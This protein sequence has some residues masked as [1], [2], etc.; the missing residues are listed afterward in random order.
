MHGIHIVWRNVLFIA[1]Y[2]RS[3]ICMFVWLAILYPRS[4]TRDL[5]VT[6]NY[7]EIET[8]YICLLVIHRD[9][10]R[11]GGGQHTSPWTCVLTFFIP[12]NSDELQINKYHP[13]K[14]Y[15]FKRL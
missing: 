12:V 13:G 7:C 3:V 11:W 9:S 15:D 1:C 6:Q 14:K 2:P 4:T 5:L 8:L 10:L